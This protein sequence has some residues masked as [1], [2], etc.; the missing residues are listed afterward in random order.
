MSWLGSIISLAETEKGW[1][2]I[3]ILESYI[4]IFA[5]GMLAVERMKQ[6]LLDGLSRLLL[7]AFQ[8]N[9]CLNCKGERC[10]L[11]LNNLLNDCGCSK[12]NS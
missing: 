8:L 7:V 11:V 4:V 12:P 2:K 9:D 10:V 6:M 1:I 3:Y 5:Q